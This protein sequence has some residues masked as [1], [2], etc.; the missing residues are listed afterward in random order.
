MCSHFTYCFE[1]YTCMYTRIYVRIYIYSYID[2]YKYMP[3]VNT[4]K[5]FHI[6]IYAYIWM[7]FTY[8]YIFTHVFIFEYINTC[9][10]SKHEWTISRK[11]YKYNHVPTPSVPL[12]CFKN[13]IFC[14]YMCVSSTV[15]SI[16]LFFIV[17]LVRVLHT[18]FFEQLLC[19]IIKRLVQGCDDA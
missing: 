18:R 6:Y 5:Q 9:A 2:I 14:K 11:Y 17:Y 15:D 7:Y 13:S 12:F 19:V 10:N 8:T 1:V 4:P 3:T 16:F